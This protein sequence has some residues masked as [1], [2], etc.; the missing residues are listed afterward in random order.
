MLNKPTKR[1]DL[2]MF[3]ESTAKKTHTHKIY[4]LYLYHHHQRL[5]TGT[6]KKKYIVEWW[7][8]WFNPPKLNY[9]LH[10]VIFFT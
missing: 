2:L 8:W 6:I 9:L 4:N 5:K 10:T 3:P 1:S 7:W